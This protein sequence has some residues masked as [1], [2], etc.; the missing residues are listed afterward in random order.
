MR[1]TRKVRRMH[2]FLLLPDSVDIT[3]FDDPRFDAIKADPPA[4][5]TVED[6]GGMFGLRCHRPGDTLLDAIARTCQEVQSH[7]NIELTDL[8]VEK[9]WEWR[10]DG[11]N[12]YGAMIV[13]QLA[14]MARRRARPLGYGTDAIVD[15]LLASRPD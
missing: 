5:C 14:L 10:E 1:S 3:S 8:G 15:L 9:L 4:G 11:P 7:F 2:E 13:A 12:G 6:V